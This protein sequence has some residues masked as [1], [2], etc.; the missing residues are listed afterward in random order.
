MVKLEPSEK[1][2]K[3]GK[4]LFDDDDFFVM[5]KKKTKAPAEVKPEIKQPETKDI[6]AVEEKP[7]SRENPEPIHLPLPPKAKAEETISEIL[8]SDDV[9]ESFHTAHN[10][11]DAEE[12]FEVHNTKTISDPVEIVSDEESD[13]EFGDLIKAHSGQ[14]QNNDEADRLYE[15]TVT[16]KLGLDEQ[17]TI[18]CRGNQTFME[19]LDNMRIQAMRLFVP[20]TL[21]GGCLIWIDGKLELKPFFRPSTLRIPKPSKPALKTLLNCLYIPEGCRQDFDEIYP[22]FHESTDNGDAEEDLAIVEMKAES[23]PKAEEEKKIEYFI[24]GLKGK[25]N[26]RI[27]AEVGPQT[28]IRAL[29]QHYLKS[30]EIDERLV[31]KARLV[32]DD[33]DLDL[34]GVVGDTELEEDFEV[35]VYIN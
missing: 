33:E 18:T 14:K 24:I 7:Q 3:R 21:K 34:D 10:T 17:H 25:D 29:L 31:S 2:K 20:F 35:Q 6:S 28:K 30:K 12:I 22:E 11:S 23:A 15:L 13:G 19:I 5:K 32:F 27:E 8:V 16:S 26:K 4:K 1:A 9:G